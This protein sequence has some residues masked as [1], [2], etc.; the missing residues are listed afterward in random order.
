MR[1]LLD[2]LFPPKCAACARLLDFTK[3]GESCALC[4][5]CLMR[6][7]A[8]KAELC[9]HCLSSVSACTCM[10]DTL[11]RVRCRGLFKLTYYKQGNRSAVQN[12][13]VFRIKEVRDF[14]TPHFLSGE[15]AAA[16]RAHEGEMDLSN[17]VIAYAPRRRQAYR[18]HGTDQARELAVALSRRLQIPMFHGIVR[19]RGRQKEQKALTPRERLRNARAS[20]LIRD[21]ELV[22][23]KTVLLVDDIVT[24]GASMAACAQHLMRA[25]AEAVYGVAVASDDANQNPTVQ[26]PKSSHDNFP[27][28][29]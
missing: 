27:S 2:L 9:G 25:G 19:K 18:L 14:R 3:A 12:R 17:A 15:L 20:F 13:I 5:G 6:W 21:G 23:G 28:G 24:T 16:I 29:H 8:A 4:D 10:T 26:I 7:N 22:S 1:R 11:S